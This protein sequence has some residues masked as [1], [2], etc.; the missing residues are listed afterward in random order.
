VTAHPSAVRAEPIHGAV[1]IP[2]HNEEHVIV[3]TLEGLAPLTSTGTVDIVVVCNG[4]SDDTAAVAR[5]FPGVT[6]IETDIPSKP[7]A[8][9]LGDRATSRW[10]RLYLDGDIGIEASAV[11][12]V[13]AELSH[14][15]GPLASRPESIV[16][17][18]DATFPVRAYYRAR[19]RIPE[20]GTRLWGAG[21]YAVSQ[22][23][24]ER[25]A[26]FP[27]VTADDSYFDALFTEDEKTIA[28]SVPMQVR[29]PRT[30]GTL[31]DILTRHRRG[32]VELDGP[33]D[34]TRRVQSLIGS[35]RGV[36]SAVDAF[37]YVALTAIARLR[38]RRRVGL[39]TSEWERDP[40][41]RVADVA[42]LRGTVKTS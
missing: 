32:Q 21:G 14:E 5:R 33:S 18:S 24:H 39:G 4:C 16:D 30:A 20:V 6:V 35:V 22:L 29:A 7:N 25:F 41:T 36:P 10:P 37:S 26:A 31:L 23:G 9:N 42:D 3:R 19:A 11:A 28:P 40:S 12:A 2:A 27:D 34:S 38:S 1:I 8:M 13:F 17:A 15:G